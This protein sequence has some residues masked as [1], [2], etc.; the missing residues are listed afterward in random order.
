MVQETRRI[1]Y[2]DD[3]AIYLLIKVRIPFLAKVDE[4]I[5]SVQKVNK[6]GNHCCLLGDMLTGQ[7]QVPF[8]S[9]ADISAQSSKLK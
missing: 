9:I 3:D 6:P 4:T 8:H 2:E 7:V 1:K 5:Y